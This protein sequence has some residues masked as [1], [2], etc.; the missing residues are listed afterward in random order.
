MWQPF[1]C[2]TNVLHFMQSYNGIRT[3]ELLSPINVQCRLQHYV[4]ARGRLRLR[5]HSTIAFSYIV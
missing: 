4:F 5:S 3:T 2:Y 1:V